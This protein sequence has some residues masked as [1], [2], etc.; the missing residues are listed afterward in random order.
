MEYVKNGN[1]GIGCIPDL[2]R[3][4]ELWCRRERTIHGHLMR[5][6]VVRFLKKL[7]SLG[8]N[9]FDTAN[10]YSNGTSEEIVG[11]ALKDYANRDEIVT[12]NKGFFPNA[13]KVRMVAGFPERQL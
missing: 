2:S 7:L 6:T 9:F 12:R 5:S 11:R 4:Y 1:T 3:L 13:C 10:F 8:I